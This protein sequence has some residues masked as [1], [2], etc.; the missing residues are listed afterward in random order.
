VLLIHQPTGVLD[1]A[2]RPFDLAF[3]GHTHAGQIVLPGG[4]VLVVPAG[5]LSRKYLYGRYPLARGRHLFVSSGVG[6]S[7]LPIRL[8]AP[9]EVVICTVNGGGD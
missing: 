3:A 7:V 2:G 6:N 8:G 1:A 4:I 5:A 9:A